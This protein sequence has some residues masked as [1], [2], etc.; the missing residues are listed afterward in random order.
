MSE[1]TKEFPDKEGHY[2]FYGYRYGRIS[3]GNETE[4][5][6]ILMENRKITNGWMLTGG[7]QFV[8]ESE[9]ESPNFMP[10]DLPEPPE[11]FK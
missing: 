1:W 10:A 6:L 2:W 8:F 7:G 4:P 5:E 3:C 9:V 11:L